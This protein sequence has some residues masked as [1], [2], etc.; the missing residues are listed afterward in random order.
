MQDIKEKLIDLVN[1]PSYQYILSN[2]EVVPDCTIFHRDDYHGIPGYS[3]DLLPHEM[4]R[5]NADK[6]MKNLLDRD[7]LSDSFYLFNIELSDGDVFKLQ[8]AL[9]IEDHETKME[10]LRECTSDHWVGDIGNFHDDNR[11]LEAVNNLCKLQPHTDKVQADFEELIE[12]AHI[13]QKTIK[14]KK[15]Q[16][17]KK[18][19]IGLVNTPSYQYILSN[20]EVIPNHSIYFRDAYHDLR[21]ELLPHELL[22]HEMMGWDADKIMENLLDRDVESDYYWLFLDISFYIVFKLQEA[23]QIEDH[24]TKM[25]ALRKCT[26][27]YHWVENIDDD[28]LYLKAVNNLILLRP[29]TTQ[30]QADFEELIGFSREISEEMQD[31][32]NG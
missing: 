27:R 13:L 29:H 19:L 18:K 26:S 5:W 21:E 7:D 14:D 22:P 9:Q 17:I 3:Y 8:E 10:A 2:S 31:S 15:M 23:L 16:D 1:S 6:I 11:Y 24:E 32:T 30:V 12:S 20:S 4:I 28:E 25:E